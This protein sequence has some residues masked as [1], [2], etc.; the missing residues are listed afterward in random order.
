MSF[1]VLQAHHNARGLAAQVVLLH[2]DSLTPSLLAP[3]IRGTLQ[4]WDG[5]P[6]DF[7]NAPTEGLYGPKGWCEA[8]EPEFR[9]PCLRVGSQGRAVRGWYQ[10]AMCP[11]VAVVVTLLSMQMTN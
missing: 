5:K 6:S 10:A 11:A 4:G 1:G 9:C 8:D 3:Q 2:V 7:G